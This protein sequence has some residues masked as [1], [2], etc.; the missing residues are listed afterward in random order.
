MDQKNVTVAGKRTKFNR[1][2]FEERFFICTMLV[3]AVVNFLIFWVYLNFSSI[4]LAFQSIDV[5]GKTHWTLDNFQMIFSELTGAESVIAVALKNTMI[6]FVANLFIVMPVS[7]LLC[8]FLYKRITGYRAFR[9]IF[10][11]PSIIA[12]SIYVMLFKYIISY[13]GPV[14]MLLAQFG[15]GH[16]DFLVEERAFRTILTY[17]VVTSFGGNIILLSGAVSHIDDSIIEAGKIDGV[18]M[19]QEL[20][21]LVIPLIWPTLSTLLL[22]QFVGIFNSSG[23]ILLFTKGQYNTTTISYWI[24]QQ[25]NDNSLYNYPAAV[26]IVCTAIGVP[27]SLFM[28][29]L[30]NRGVED[31]E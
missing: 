28:R 7:V 22:F 18:N 11:L 10:Y 31:V 16:I 3:T 15:V 23:P 1:K 30:L 21:Y 14:D 29:W 6:F 5:N 20:F 24:F 26:G 27:L 2:Y 17:T 8:Y 19:W 13:D 4:L 9:F 25:V 12:G